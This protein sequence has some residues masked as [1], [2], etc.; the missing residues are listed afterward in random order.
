VSTEP[1]A[2][3]A[4]LR[5]A[6]DRERAA[7]PGA[8]TTLRACL[9]DLARARVR[10]CAWKSNEHL[11][12][13]LAG[14][15]DLDLL[16]DARDAATFASVVARR[17][18]KPLVP[19]PTAA[20]PGVRHYLGFDRGSGRLYHLHAYFALV[21][22]QRY[23][24]NHHLPLE[25]ELLDSA[26]TLH[27]VPVP[28]P[29]V[30][31]AILVLRALLKYRARDLI[32][33]VLRVRS[34]GIPEPTRAEIRWLRS[35]GAE[36]TGLGS[37]AVGTVVPFDIVSTFLQL[38]ET[39]PRPG[40]DILRLKARLER[41]LRG[42]QRRSRLHASA[43]Y[44]RALV[45][46]RRRRLLGQR[47]EPGMTL[48]GGGTTVALIGADGAG[49]STVADEVARWLGWKLQTR[50]RY[51]GSKQPSYPTTWLY[52]GFRALRRGHRT[53]SCRLG[54]GSAAAIPLAGLRDLA[55]ALH[56]VA[57]GLDRRRHLARAR[58][59]ARA[60]A[61]VLT[62]RYPLGCLSDR[63]DHR[64]LDGPQVEA[65]L[66]PRLSW[67]VSILASAER[68]LYGRFGLPDHLVLLDVDPVVAAGR[69]PDHRLDVI[70]TKSRAA[71]ELAGLAEAAGVAV[72]RVDA[73]QPLDRVLLDVKG[74]LWDV[75]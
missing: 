25:R 40:V 45:R 53:A 70:R 11:L 2:I 13:A 10:L 20:Y 71:A 33:D 19:P 24:K 63:L 35:R 31:L 8:G 69:K 29:D 4:E 56:H 54:E 41:S 43:T 59:D 39:H 17:D 3:D 44:G 26:R 67:P 1:V 21:L 18:F 15:T 27:G 65:V 12:A 5:A 6:G 14:E 36:A 30:E 23:A 38:M 74:G 42:F 72:T 48:S 52:V 60:G 57:V 32:K 28:A 62:D 73:D 22:G 66:G 16:V 9:G 47:D 64:L 49:K 7:Q 68:R 61:I 51:L 75:L 34:P 46:R 37:D 55:L 50:V 58:H